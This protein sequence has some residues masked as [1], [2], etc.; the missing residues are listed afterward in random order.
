MKIIKYIFLFS[1]WLGYAQE[2]NNEEL[3]TS[4]NGACD[5]IA[6]IELSSEDKND[7]I[8]DCITNSLE[9]ANT[10]ST[11]ES[12]DNT[13]SSKA[14][15]YK[16]VENY[17]V[18]HC[19]PLKELAFTE[20]KKFK[21]ASS[22][23]VLAQLAYD[24]GMEYINQGDTENAILKFS[25][26]VD[27]DP[28]FAFAWDNLGISY[29][30]NK[31]YE[32]AINAYLKSLEIYPEGRLPLLNIAITYNLNQQYEKAVVYYEK[33]I[34]I[35]TDDPEGYYGLGLILYTQDQEEAGLDNLIR[36]YTIYTN[37]N[38]PY[39]ADAAKKIGYMYKDLKNQNKLDIF[40][41]VADKYNLKVQSN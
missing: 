17:L 1:V 34:E 11:N 8:K 24:D 29:R 12:K 38:S 15:N 18:Q 30:K 22:N 21:Y 10:A 31:Q 6:K 14:V 28:M 3:L 39:R 2:Q 26:A 23:N 4:V 25:K 32:Q 36:A 5:C 27:I 41:K 35:Y 16:M 13:S 40:H 20:N 19:K 7:R 33:F 37:Q 9:N